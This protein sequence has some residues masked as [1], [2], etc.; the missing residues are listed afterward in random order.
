[1]KYF[2]TCTSTSL[3]AN[4]SLGVE[5]VLAFLLWW[6]MSWLDG[7]RLTDTHYTRYINSCQNPNLTTSQPQPNLNLLGF[8][9]I[10]PLHTPHPPTTRPHQELYFYQK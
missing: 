10:I 6:D 4:F 5:H 3:C 1:M 8:D 2:S 9:T 7:A